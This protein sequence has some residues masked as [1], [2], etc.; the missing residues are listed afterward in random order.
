LGDRAFFAGLTQAHYIQHIPCRRG[1][2]NSVAK[3]KKWNLIG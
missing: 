1:T 3:H 2:L